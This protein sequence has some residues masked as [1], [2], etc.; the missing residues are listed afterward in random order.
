MDES[1]LDA[2][3]EIERL[4]STYGD[5]VIRP[6]TSD[7]RPRGFWWGLKT[8][9]AMLI[10]AGLLLYGS[11]QSL[12]SVDVQQKIASASRAKKPAAEPAKEPAPPDEVEVIPAR[13]VAAATTTE[14]LG[15]SA[16][17]KPSETKPE[18]K[19]TPEKPVEPKPEPVVH[20]AD[21]SVPATPPK[22]K[23]APKRQKPI[24]VP[25]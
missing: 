22:P 10:L 16:D 14:V 3:R 7:V 21:G 8:G 12:A 17:T 6:D 2:A 15:K 19:S 24:T 25:R 9:G 18:E 5:I 23:P 13:E 1:K 4:R 11:I 20:I